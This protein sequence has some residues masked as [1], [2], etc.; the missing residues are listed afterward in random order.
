MLGLRPGVSLSSSCGNGRTHSCADSPPADSTA[1]SLDEATRFVT[2]PGATDATAVDDEGTRFVA[3]STDTGATQ[4]DEEQTQ[5]RTLAGND[6]ATAIE[7]GTRL[8]F[9]DADD[10]PTAHGATLDSAG[11]SRGPATTSA[12]RRQV[13]HAPRGSDSGPLKVGQAFSNRYHIIRVLGIGGMGAVYQ[14]WDA[15]LGM[16]VALKVIRPEATTDQAAAREME[17]RFKQ[18]LVLARQ[19]THKNVVRI[20]D[21]GEIDGIKYIT[22]PYLDGSDLATIMKKDGKMPVPAA[23]RI[24]RDVA[25]GLVA[26]HEAGIV[27]RDLKPANIMVLSDHAVIMDFGI[28]RSSTAVA[29]EPKKQVALPSGVASRQVAAAATVVGTIMGTV[30]YMAPE[31]ARAEAVDQRADIYA[32]GLIFSDMLLGKRQQARPDENAFDELK[33]RL[34]EPP[35]K[36]RTVDPTIPEALEN[37]IARSV[38]TDAA[39]RFQTSKELVAELDRLDENGVPIPIK[40]TISLPY[41]VGVVASLLALSVSVWWYQR[42]FIPAAEH[43][44][45]SVLI[46]DFQNDTGDPTFNRTLEPMLKLALEGA[47]FISAYDRVGVSRS[48][49]VRPPEE[50][51]ERAAQEIAVKQGVGVVLSGSVSRRGN[52]YTVKAQASRAVT[53]EVIVSAEDTASSRDQVLAAATG[54]ASEVRD[55]LGDDTSDSAQRFAMQ[56]L[57]ATSLEAVRDYAV[58]QGALSNNRFEDARQ[59]YLKAIERDPN[60]GAAYSGMAIASRNLGFLE[61]GEKYAREAVRHLDSMTER[62]R[63]RARGLLYYVTNDYPACVKEY[64]DLVAQYAADVAARNNLALCLTFLRDLPRALDEMRRAVEILPKRAMYRYNLALYASYAGDFPSA[65][66]EAQA[67]RELGNPL[68]L[69]SLAFAQLGQSQLTQAA[70]TY[71]QLGMIDAQGLSFATSGLGDLAA[72]EGRF[73][74]AAR[75]LEGG[76]AADLMAKNTDKAA[77]KF[78]ALAHA[79]LS[80]GQPRAA[81]AAADLALKNSQAVRIRFLAARVLAEAGQTARARALAKGLASEVQAEPQAYAKIVEGMIALKASERG[82]A[83]KAFTEA[84]TLLDT[85]IGHFDLGRAYVDAGMFA[86]ADSEFDRCFKRRGEVLALFLDEEPTYS[87]LPALYYYQGRAREG[88]GTVGFVESYRTYLGIREKAGED[89]LLPEVRKRA[90]TRG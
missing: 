40:K 7:E 56:T 22:M 55:A 62:E 43:A 79:R 12:T 23:L 6:A 89:P 65:E 75:I 11:K 54:L 32:L 27:H 83:I 9:G 74:D 53:G 77:A 73:Q 41:L 58:G 63:Y 64:G 38:E 36:V 49:G 8:P 76:A 4:L 68:G 84:N 46:A 69:L 1:T 37:L 39:A 5:L 25:A 44:P 13:G 47:S 14:A 2:P 51:N 57:S 17:R 88:L 18:E 85:W 90:A 82:P 66:T 34:K 72:Y 16:A 70:Q 29:T 3:P 42:Q 48:L 31:Q 28:A 30:Q 15:E 26:A 35:P 20:H 59:S 67:S 10:A 45:V 24:V 50:L 21:L 60:F 71:Q 61:E 86:Q 78:A 33:R 80:Q 87:F 81:V 52:G 19:V